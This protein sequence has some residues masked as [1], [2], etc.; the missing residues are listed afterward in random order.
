M[1]SC[2][3]FG[4]GL[5]DWW[6]RWYFLSEV[7]A[8][9]DADSD[10]DGLS[11]YQE[12]LT[13]T[14]PLDPWSCFDILLLLNSVPRQVVLTWPSTSN[15][16]YRIEVADDATHFRLFRQAIPATPPQNRETVSRVGEKQYFRT[17]AE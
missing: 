14:D 5:P 13:G 11:N 3:V 7:G 4:H 12:Y 1:R 17:V 8:A 6:E 10:A 16:T 15:R 9:S 2:Y